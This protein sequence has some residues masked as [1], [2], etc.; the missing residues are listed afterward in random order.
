[1]SPLMFTNHATF[2][3]FI[4]LQQFRNNDDVNLDGTT[5]VLCA[6]NLHSE[7]FVKKKRTKN[8]LKLAVLPV[9]QINRHRN[10]IVIVNIHSSP[11]HSDLTRWIDRIKK[12]R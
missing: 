7:L 2:Q 12:C 3:S 4:V 6:D 11:N 9:F 10:Q 8:Y 5:I 1:M